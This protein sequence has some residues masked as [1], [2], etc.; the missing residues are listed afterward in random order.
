MSHISC[1]GPQQVDKRTI[2]TGRGRGVVG[3]P[4]PCTLPQGPVGTIS[5]GAPPSPLCDTRALTEE[6]P[7]PRALAAL[8]D[9]PTV[10]YSP[11]TRDT[12]AHH[13]HTGRDAE[14]SS[15]PPMLP[16]LRSEL[17]VPQG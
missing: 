4:P 14:L 11:L 15:Y 7:T 8:R 9:S 12:R 5:P 10:M 17:P 6:F 2:A 3:T 16:S 13:C 1:G